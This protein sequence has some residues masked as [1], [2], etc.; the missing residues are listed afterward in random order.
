MVSFV[1]RLALC[2]L[3]GPVK[4]VRTKSSSDFVG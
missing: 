1:Y 2:V 3:E 4:A